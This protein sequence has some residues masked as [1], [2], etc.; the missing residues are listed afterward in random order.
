VIIQPPVPAAEAEAAIPAPR[1]EPVPSVAPHGGRLAVL[2][3][4]NLGTAE[5]L[6]TRLAQEGTERGFDVSLGALDEHVDD[7]PRDGAT[8]IVCSTYN[9]TPP[10]NAAAFCR[11][12]ANAP[13][14]AARGV[15]YTVFG[16]GNTEWASTYQGVPTMLDQQLEA[17]GG[18]RLHPRGEGN[19][20]GDFDAAYR[21]WHGDLWA[22]T[23]SALG[24]PAAAA[25]AAPAGPRLSITLTNR[26]VSNPVIMSYRARPARVRVNRE[27][28]A[29]GPGGTPDRSTRHL[30]IALPEGMPYRAGDHLGV[31]P[32][33]NV[34][35]IRRAIARF[36]LDA[37]QYLTIIP[38]GGTHTHLPIDEPTPLL[39]V[40]ASCVE[41][42]DVARRGDIEVLAR[43][44][45]DPAQK[46]ALQ[47]LAGDDEESQARYREQVF[48]PN[49]SVLD[50]LDRFPACRL[51]FE[52]YL[53]MLPPLR[54]RYYSI[55]SS[56]V[57]S[58]EVCSITTGVV[59][60]PARSGS[61]MFT[62]VASGH[63]AQLPQDG[64]VFV[65]VR[66][67]SIA[68]RPPPATDVP[69]IM[70]G[71][72]TGL[73]PFRGFLQERAAQREQGLPVARSLLFFGC[74]TSLGDQ[75]YAD[76]LRDHERQGV[77]R[78]E[79][80]YSQEPGR[81]GR[82]VQEAVLDCADEVWDLLQQGAVV[83]VCGNAAT[84]APGVRRSLAHIFRERTSA[85]DADAEA[86][87]AGLR[88]ADRFVEDIWGG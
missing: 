53:D 38:N 14:D 45:D 1:A 37:G 4:S 59:R 73:A 42:Q 31:L 41:L 72:G 54:P 64:T 28:L 65:F 35:L 22:E 46:A 17:H 48:A 29:A 3:G 87:L 18:R 68:F 71:A 63:L 13:P 84:I 58:P 39:G 69:M 75:L 52:E 21:S 2:F 62:G 7:L 19:V 88:A 78:V 79:T 25:A 56:P 20:A 36:G 70:V 43:Y 6:A 16:C 9:G 80:A 51:P 40:L 15:S 23:A 30:E 55:S 83:L 33:N 27:L 82:Y 44:T 57:V 49:R 85:T 5:A 66:E 11:W 32:R 60:G 8:V 76:E 47:S 81:P 50:L 10:D 26:Q 67:P 77:V 24:L 61:G 12:I 86:W 74:R 34:D